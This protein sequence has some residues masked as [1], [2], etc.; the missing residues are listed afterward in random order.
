MTDKEL[1]QQLSKLLQ[2]AYAE[3]NNSALIELLWKEDSSD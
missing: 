1:V 3:G 2:W